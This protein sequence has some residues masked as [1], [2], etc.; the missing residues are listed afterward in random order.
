M[1]FATR[2]ITQPHVI[3]REAIEAKTDP[4]RGL[5][6]GLELEPI[7]EFFLAQKPP[8]IQKAGTRVLAGRVCPE[9]SAPS[10]MNIVIGMAINQHRAEQGRLTGYGTLRPLLSL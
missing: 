1:A 3:D 5:R 7:A 10:D 8:D 2:H 6:L 4:G 9:S